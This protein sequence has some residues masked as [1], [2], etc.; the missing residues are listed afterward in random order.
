MQVLEQQPWSV[1]TSLTLRVV[2][3][4]M[5]QVPLMLFAI[6]IDPRSQKISYEIPLLCEAARFPKRKNPIRRPENN[7]E[8]YLCR[9]PLPITSKKGLHPEST[10]K[11]KCLQAMAF[12]EKDTEE[13]FFK[14][15][16]TWDSHSKTRHKGTA[17]PILPLKETVSSLP[18]FPWIISCPGPLF[19]TC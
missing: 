4:A 5:W 13:A 10:A 12:R 16:K 6:K 17:R 19:A 7:A 3:E 8:K 14:N 15:G 18:A 1:E 11:T 2:P 9:R